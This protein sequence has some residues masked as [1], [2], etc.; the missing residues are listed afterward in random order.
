MSY[1]ND[2]MTSHGF[3]SMNKARDAIERQLVYGERRKMMQA[4]GDYLD[5]LMRDNL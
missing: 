1:T 3:H 4:H 2:E 5:N